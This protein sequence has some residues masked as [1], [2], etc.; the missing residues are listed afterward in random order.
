M[1]QENRPKN[2]L[3]RIQHK[4]SF[5]IHPQANHSQFKENFIGLFSQFVSKI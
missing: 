2:R 3:M 4:Q 5:P 1:K